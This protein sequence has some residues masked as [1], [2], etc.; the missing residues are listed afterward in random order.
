MKKSTVAL[1]SLALVILL[2][3]GGVF[4]LIRNLDRIVERAIEKYGTKAAGTSVR[5]EGVKI[6]LKAG[7]GSVS[8]LTIANP[9]GF[10]NQP[11]FRLG[12][13]ILDLDT[14]SLTSEVPVIDEIRIT[15]PAFLVEMNAKG[16]TNIGV[17]EKNLGRRSGGGGA[18]QEEKEEHQEPV[19]LK[20]RKIVIEGG[21]G[22]LDLTA[23]GGKRQEAKLPVITL[24]NLGGRNGITPE[25]LSETV[26][27]ALVKAAEQAAARKG[28]EKAIRNQIQEKTDEALKKLLGE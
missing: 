26:L 6:G 17:I 5:A 23:V 12:G 16:Q 4:F 13:I 9:D 25:A 10:S 27:T 22:V 11:A 28:V 15:D 14:A 20:I 7:R 1:I 19:R 3:G 21:G 18:K 24:T 8:G 2:L